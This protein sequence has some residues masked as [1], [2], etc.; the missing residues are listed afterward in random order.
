MRLRRSMLI[1]PLLAVLT[2]SMAPAANA[3][4]LATPTTITLTWTA[5]GDDSLLGNATLYDLRYSTAPITPA[6]FLAAT[7]ATG[8]P[9]PAA[10]G[11]PQTLT[12]T[13]LTPA[14]TYYF[15]MRSQ[16][17]ASNWSGISNTVS[18]ATLAAPDVTLPAPI[19]SL[20]INALTD[21]TATLGWTAV[22]DDSLTGTAASYDVRFST[23][24]ITTT[25][26]ATAIQVTGEPAPAAPGTAQTFMVRNLS[27]QTTY[28]FAIKTTDDAS[29]VSALSNTPSGSTTDTLPPAA[30]RDLVASFVWLSWSTAA[31]H[32]AGME[33]PR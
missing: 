1:T 31:R 3:A 29:N 18:R 23:Q 11:T 12:V 25:S 19:A 17:D 8:L 26:W 13:G 28:Y 4:A 15:A 9:A 5:P 6:N 10:P 22:G 2:L 16:D 33:P 20:G 27:R 24:P 7:P 32:P 14:T 30:I 21:T